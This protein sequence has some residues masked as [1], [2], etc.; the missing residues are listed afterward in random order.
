MAGPGK[1]RKKV[2]PQVQKKPV[3]KNNISPAYEQFYERT[4]RKHL[5]FLGV[6]EDLF[7]RLNKRTRKEFMSIRKNPPVFLT[8]EGHT[9]PKVYL[10]I[11]TDNLNKFQRTTLYCNNP[12]GY[13]FEE[14]NLVG[15]LFDVYAK[16]LIEG[17][18]LPLDQEE[19]LYPAMAAGQD[20]EL[21][22][23]H[24]SM[25]D[26]ISIFLS[27]ILNAL[28]RINYRF[29]TCDEGFRKITQLSSLGKCY[30]VYSEEGDRKVFNIDNVVR[31]GWRLGIIKTGTSTV[32]VFIQRG[33]IN[34]G[35][36]K[37]QLPVYIQGHALQRM[38]ERMN[39]SST[40]VN[41]SFLCTFAREEKLELESDIN[42]RKLIPVLDHTFLKVGYFAFTIADNCVLIQS[43]LPLA[44][45]IT[46]EGYAFKKLLNLEKKDMSY[47][48]MD[49]L[50]FYTDN[51]LERIPVL[52]KALQKAGMWHL[53]EIMKSADGEFEFHILKI[54]LKETYREVEG[55]K[56]EDSGESL[57]PQRKSDK[58]LEKF[59]SS[60][61][62]SS[63]QERDKKKINQ[64]KRKVKKEE[65]PAAQVTYE[66]IKEAAE[67]GFEYL[68]EVQALGD[69]IISGR[70]SFK[71][72]VE[73]SHI[74]SGM[75]KD[76]IEGIED[77]EL[78][79]H[80]KQIPEITLSRK[81][82]GCWLL[83]VLPLAFYWA[84]KNKKAKKQNIAEVKIAKAKYV[85]IEKIMRRK[86]N[87][88][89]TIH[90]PAKDVLDKRQRPL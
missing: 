68:H 39:I 18:K 71:D 35:Y 29:Y 23:V 78:T 26:T 57:P 80:A 55:L 4:I 34:G 19:I 38:K 76:I 24:N 22:I 75:K 17:K 79:Y 87:P 84:H 62:I 61:E 56:S 44:D 5:L 41:I 50:S 27:Q 67:A 37:E 51:D 64:L 3:S 70:G 21:D 74:S 85:E 33:K 58:L 20:P 60:M 9:V 15:Q 77:E 16:Y 52:K 63:L 47:W 89:K 6:E 36:S 42:G 45:P 14:Y 48:K 8:K 43:F 40:Y 46:V 2:Q 1:K 72:I 54:A 81:T 28:S 12:F 86:L 59:F 13:T 31:V 90:L 53:T 73:F 66:E 49:K 25:L 10:K 11:L 32:W 69:K 7:E 82:G 30:H 65:E 83:F 88:G